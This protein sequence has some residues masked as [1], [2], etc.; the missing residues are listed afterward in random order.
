[1]FREDLKVTTAVTMSLEYFYVPRRTDSDNCG[2]NVCNISM[3]REELK[4][5]T[6]VPMSL[7]HFYVP[8]RADSDNCGNNES[9]I[10]LC[11]GK[12]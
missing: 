4:V 10:F 6:A 11:S 5:T 3:F 7:E 12:S 9:A 2:N 1:M 8:R